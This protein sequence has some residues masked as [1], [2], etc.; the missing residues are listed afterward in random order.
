MTGGPRRT[1][2]TL[3]VAPFLLVAAAC[4]DT[5]NDGDSAD[6]SDVQAARP[7]GFEASA[8]YL[9]GVVEASSSQPY[10]FEAFITMGFE[11]DGEFEGITDV[12]V[13]SGASDGTR[14]SS[15]GDISRMV[16]EMASVDGSD[17][18]FDPDEVDLGIETVTDGDDVYVRAPGY[19]EIADLLA[20]PDGAVP[21]MIT[22]V[23]D[24]GDKWGHVD[25]SALDANLLPGQV[26]SQLNQGQNLDP[27]FYIELLQD[28]QEVDELG[29]DM[30]DGV[31]AIGLAADVRMVALL[32][33]Q[34]VDPE[35]VLAE[36]ASEDADLA[37]D[38]L[39]SFAF[40]MEVWLDEA[41]DVRELTM[42]VGGATA[43]LLAELG[44]EGPPEGYQLAT[45]I[46][47]SDHGDETIEI[48]VPA[49]SDTVDIT[50]SVQDLAST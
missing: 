2:T 19:A 13:M 6:G 50:D 29:V 4:G 30:I 35:T 17:L 40:P 33:A 28:T 46:R 9:S 39:E 25:L 31:S 3:L 36:V 32:E 47:F 43:D 45:T 5:E 48:A 49:P 37:A 27:A 21:P 11:T 20:N 16:E 26:F 14:S 15:D 12:P 34:G 41:G 1:A 24:L 10:R 18:P 44:E 8:A 38:V 42:D 22:A 7:P 23:M